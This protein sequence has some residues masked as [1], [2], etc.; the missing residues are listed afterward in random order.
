MR[1][2]LKGNLIFSKTKEQLSCYEA[3]YIVVEAGKV[4]GIYKQLPQLYQQDKVIDYGDA[5]IIPGF[6][7]IHAH[8]PQWINGGMGY[9]LELL[10]WLDQYT[11]PLEATYADTTFAINEYKQ[12]IN[13]LWEVG[14]TRI[15]SMAT[16]HK[17]ATNELI[18][19][20]KASG[21]GAYIGKVN[22]DRNASEALE[23][24]TIT[25]LIETEELIRMHGAK[26]PLV[27]Y[28]VSPRFVP[29]TTEHLM[30]ELGKIV[31]KYKLPVQSHLCENRNEVALV[32]KLHPDIPSFTEVYQTYGLL[33]KGRT[34]MA[35]C[36]YNTEAEIALLKAQDVVVAHCAQS[37]F[38]LASGIMP[39]RRY[40]EEG[41]Q[42]GLGSDVGGGHSL[43]MK[44]HIIATI[45]A[46]KMYWVTHPEAKPI[47]L[48]EAFYLATKG[49]GSFFGAVGS[50]ENDYSFDA[51]IIQDDNLPAYK[52]GRAHV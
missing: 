18:K 12:F 22:M 37:N 39:L 51:L 10:P 14:T 24:N 36:I 7:D 35:H 28:I 3:H 19:L 32:K 45:N 26:H 33:P 43:D 11:F 30:I 38:N 41:I 16:K 46:S 2:I 13:D 17:E 15:C 5:L 29:C 44:E 50:F 47:S 49:G 40:L 42:V 21:L 34:V 52:I 20:F 27:N 31:D 6:V 9:D 48:S 25:S 1:K 23:E 8:V 4:V